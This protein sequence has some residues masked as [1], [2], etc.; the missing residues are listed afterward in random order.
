MSQYMEAETCDHFDI[1]EV[2]HVLSCLGYSCFEVRF[3]A[4]PKYGIGTS[5]KVLLY[6]I[7]IS[8]TRKKNIS[9][10]IT[11]QL[12]LLMYYCCGQVVSLP[13]SYLESPCFTP[14]H[15]PSRHDT[16]LLFFLQTLQADV[17]VLHQTRPRPLP[18]HPVMLHSLHYCWLPS[19]HKKLYLYY[20]AIC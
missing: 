1:S 19:S 2:T 3:T 9:A 10:K 18:C 16:F 5:H 4:L 17:R 13:A 7:C 6:Y 20:T 12:M 11:Q 15:Q 14:T 8:S